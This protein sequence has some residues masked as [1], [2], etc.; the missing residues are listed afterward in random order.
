MTLFTASDSP[1]SSNTTSG[2]TA[3]ANIRRHRIGIASAA[4]VRINIT[5]TMSSKRRDDVSLTHFTNFEQQRLLHEFGV[6]TRHD[7]ARLDPN[8]ARLAR[9]SS[10]DST[11]RE[12]VLG[13]AIERLD[14]LI[15]RARVHVADSLLRRVEIDAMGCASA[16]VEV[17]VD[18]ESYADHTYLWGATVRLAPGISNLP[19]GYHSF[20]E[21]DELSDASEARIFDEFWKWFTALREESA[22]RGHTFA[23]YCFWAQAEDGA[24]NRAVESPREGGPTR[25]DLDEFRSTIPAQWIDLHEHAKAQIQTG[26]PL[27]L[28]ILARA[29][30]FE[31]RDE[32]PSGEAS[33]RWF[34]SA[35]SGGDVEVWRRRILEYNEDDCLATRALRDWLNGPAKALAHRD[36][37]VEP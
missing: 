19:S 35:R 34:E 17:D 7:L 26:G 8:L 16:D 32:N 9:R 18:M 21:W 1:C 25:H 15:Y 36:H 5:A 6:D 13:L 29:A 31:W 4:N 37:I 27:G 33:M 2:A 23:A 12:A 11:S 28:K 20:V 14:D 24:M 30:G 22:S 10:N 3:R